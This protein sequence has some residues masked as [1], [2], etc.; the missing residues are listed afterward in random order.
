MGS[1]LECAVRRG[2]AWMGTAGVTEME[3]RFPGLP[4]CSSISATE[5]FKRSGCA[6]GAHG[7]WD[8]SR[9]PC[10]AAPDVP[11]VPSRATHDLSGTDR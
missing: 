7:V 8:S 11:P 10:V 3:R 9:L 5:E 4:E 1:L 2:T 6:V